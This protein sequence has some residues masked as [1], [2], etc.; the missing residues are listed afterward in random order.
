MKTSPAFS[1]SSRCLSTKSTIIIKCLTPD[2]PEVVEFLCC[3]PEISGLSL[4][5]PWP[6]LPSPCRDKVDI[7]AL[8]FMRRYCVFRLYDWL[9]LMYWVLAGF[10]CSR[11]SIANSWPCRRLEFTRG[12]FYLYYRPKDTSLLWDETDPLMAD[13]LLIWPVT[14]PLTWSA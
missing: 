8:L 1:S 4:L 7:W 11:G 13:G 6:R 3:E 12:K 10:V 9:R 5:P 14:A 2:I